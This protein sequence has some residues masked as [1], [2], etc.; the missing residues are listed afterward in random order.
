MQCTIFSVLYYNSIQSVFSLITE[1]F[2]STS[3]FSFLDKFRK[4]NEPGA[5]QNLAPNTIPTISQ[6]IIHINAYLADPIE[7]EDCDVISFW[8]NYKHC[9]PLKEIALEYFC[10]PASS[11]S[12]ERV[13]I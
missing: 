11:V 10:I 4:R 7:L 1:Y 2:V 9:D 3:T 5:N 8:M 6:A 12:S 13:Y